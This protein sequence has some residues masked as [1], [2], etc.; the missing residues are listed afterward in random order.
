[1]K[2]TFL[3]VRGTSPVTEAGFRFFG[4]ET[5]CLQI[6]GAGGERIFIDAGTGLR[7]AGVKKCETGC[8]L[9][10]TH[11]HLD[12]VMGLPQLAAFYDPADRITIASPR[13]AGRSVEQVITRILANPFWPIPLHRFPAEIAFRDLEGSRSETP[14]RHGGLRVRWV[15]LHHPGGSTAYRI[16]EKSSGEAFVFATDVEWPE[17][18]PPE[19]DALIDL[20]AGPTPAPVFIMDGQFSRKTYPSF[21]GWGHSSWEDAVEVAT[22]GKA[23]RLFVTHHAPAS[24]DGSLKKI[25]AALKKARPS[26]LL[27]RQGMRI[28]P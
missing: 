1:V 18:T 4:G 23:G 10:L 3:G 20:I 19:K 27:A 28:A 25:E 12:H 5:T 2:I 26:S 17:A 15:P 11:Y 9:L 21:R 24:D 22:L 14:V 6:E 8:L 13:R 16:D 7:G